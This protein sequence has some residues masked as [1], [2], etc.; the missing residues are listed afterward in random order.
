MIK[1]LA[2]NTFKNTGD[3]NTF[4]ELLEV[5]NIEKDLKN[6]ISNSVNSEF[7]NKNDTSNFSE[8]AKDSNFNG[9]TNIQNNNS[10]QL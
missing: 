1:K 7:V 6:R 5:E 3:I 2:W 9:I 10:N 4:M 8:V